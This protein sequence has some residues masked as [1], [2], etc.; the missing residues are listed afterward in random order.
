MAKLDDIIANKKDFPDEVSIKL[1]DGQ[2]VTL[3]DLRGGYMKDADYRQKTSTLAREKEDFYRDYA[4]KQAALEQAQ[5]RLAET[6]QPKADASADEVQEE[7][8]RNPIA[9]RLQKQ[10]RDLEQVLVPMARSLVAMDKRMNDATV[11]ATMDL[12]KRALYEI[13]SKDPSVKPEEVLQY[14]QQNRIPNLL[15]A[16]RDMSRDK[17]IE[18][19]KEEGKRLGLEEGRVLGKKESLSPTIPLRHQVA[20]TQGHDKILNL[21]EAADAAKQDMDVMGPLLGIQQ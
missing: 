14:A 20:K 19:A 15:L 18:A 1:P 11:A 2:E 3:G 21:E 4:A 10:V 12:H 9:R 7:I 13:V 8:D 16:Y 5:Q 17:A 6:I